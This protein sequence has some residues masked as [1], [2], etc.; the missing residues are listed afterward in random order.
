MSLFK[1]CVIGYLL[2]STQLACPSKATRT[3][4]EL[5][6]RKESSCLIAVCRLILQA[7]PCAAAICNAIVH[8][9]ID[10][11]NTGSFSEARL[12]F[13]AVDDDDEERSRVLA[14][15][16]EINPLDADDADVT[17]KVADLLLKKS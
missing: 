2:I 12:I 7:S 16:G 4:E 3:V 11:G 17:I 8:M 6:N 9:E 15:M 1:L 14:N 10:Q 5:K 13:V